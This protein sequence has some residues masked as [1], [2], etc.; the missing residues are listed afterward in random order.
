MFFFSLFIT[1]C[2]LEFPLLHAPHAPLPCLINTVPHA[3]RRSS[4]CTPA[5]PPGPLQ[6]AQRTCNTGAITRTTIGG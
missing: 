5:P 2:P 4:P 6:L 3:P 1:A